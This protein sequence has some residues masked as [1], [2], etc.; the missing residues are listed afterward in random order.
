MDT[1]DNDAQ[2][3]MD[4]DIFVS[5]DEKKIEISEE[6]DIS[7]KQKAAILMVSLGNEIASDLFKKLSAKEVES[8]VLEISQLGKFSNDVKLSVLKEFNDILSANE[9]INIGGVDYA[10]S[11]LETSLGTLRASE[12]IN[13]IIYSKKGPFDL[14]RK[15]DVPQIQSLIQKEMPQTIALLLSYLEP[16]KASEVLAGLP[17]QQQAEVAKRIATIRQIS[18]DMIRDVD[19]VLEQKIMAMSGSDVLVAGGI[20]TAVEILN[21]VER[22]VEKNIIETIE[23]TDPELAE[24]IK[25]RMFIFDDIVLLDDRSIQRVIQE[26][27][28]SELAKA[29]KGTNE[30]VKEKLFSNMSS[31]AGELIK[32]EI[33]YMGPVRL[34]E[35]EEVQQKIVTIIRRLE[36][37]GEV[38]ISR[39]EQE[40][41]V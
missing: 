12:I 28:N 14:L 40:T 20:D 4:S 26:I 29:L 37:Q 11:I 17:P 8:L 41:F 3:D 27:D 16:K 7:G 15:A 9:Y 24:E 2:F 31:R 22:G 39:G 23:D 35:V 21:V 1:F 19:R 36:D 33:E 34:R 18:P 30:R 13:R 25:K 10:R 38:V 32:E 6:K 5:S